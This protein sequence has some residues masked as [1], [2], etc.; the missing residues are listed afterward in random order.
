MVEQ[1]LRNRAIA[2]HETLAAGDAG[3]RS[4]GYVEYFE[5]FFDVILMTEHGTGDGAAPS[6][7]LRSTAWMRPTARLR[8]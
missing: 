5:E 8:Q 6:R 3:L 4:A 7:P 2:A 1:R